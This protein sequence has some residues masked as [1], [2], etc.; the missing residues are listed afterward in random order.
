MSTR[1]VRFNKHHD[2]YNAGEEAGFDTA[3]AEKLVDAGI[4][5]YVKAPEKKAPPTGPQDRQLK[6]DEQK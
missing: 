3:R 5:E 1:I 2:L 4:A 6:G